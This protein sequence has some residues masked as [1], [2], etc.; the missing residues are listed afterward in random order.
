MDG[1]RDS[2]D[3]QPQIRHTKKQKVT[4]FGKAG[5]DT[6]KNK[7]FTGE[8]VPYGPNIAGCEKGMGI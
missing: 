2:L 7:F 4:D 5:G 1:K 3:S 6:V 8:F